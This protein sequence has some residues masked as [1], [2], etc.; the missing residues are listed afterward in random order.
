MDNARFGAFLAQLRRERGWTQK[1][2]AER[3]N[4]TNKAVSKWERGVGFP[5]IQLMEPLAHELEVSLLELFRTE[6]IP[7]EERPS[8]TGPEVAA[9][10]ADLAA[11]RQRLERRNATIAVLVQVAGLLGAFFLMQMEWSDLL[12]IMLGYGGVLCLSV[13]VL[14][15][16]LCLLRHRRGHPWHGL[17]ALA[18]AIFLLPVL[19]LL[20]LFLMMLIG[21]KMQ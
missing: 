1:E 7:Q 13:T 16:C 10:I 12:T 20:F 14:L 3:L 2:L 15:L 6:R 8:D 21:L 18:C 11:L 5:D 19:A 17:L 9:G 4:V